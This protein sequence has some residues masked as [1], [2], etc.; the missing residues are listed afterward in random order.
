[1]RVQQIFFM[2]MVI[3]LTACQPSSD[4]TAAQ[5]EVPHRH[6]PSHDSYQLDKLSQT[7]SQTGSPLS[8]R[9]ILEQAASLL[10]TTMLQ[11]PS[12]IWPTY[13]WS[14]VNVMLTAEGEGTI[15]WK[16]SRGGA[17]SDVAPADVPAR[18]TMGMYSFFEYQGAKTVALF[19]EK[20]DRYLDNP[21]AV[22]RIGVH[23]GFHY[24]GQSGWSY[25][26]GGART[27]LL[28]LED[29]PRLYRRLM[30]RRLKEHV[31]SGKADTPSL[32]K[33]AFW[34]Q[35]WKT[36][37]P[38][39]VNSATD[40]YEGTAEY[41]ETLAHLVSLNGCQLSES[42]L[43]QKLIEFLRTSGEADERLNTALDSEGYSMGSMGAYALRFNQKRGDWQARVK[44][45]ETPLEILFANV[46]AEAD[47]E[48]LALAQEYRKEFST[49]SQQYE[50]FIA[51]DLALVKSADAIFVVPPPQ[52]N[53][54]SKGYY[55]FY[56]D[57]SLPNVI[58]GPFTSP[59][60]FQ[61][62]DW[63]LDVDAK[64]N[65]VKLAGRSVPCGG[66]T[67]IMSSSSVV[68][69]EGVLKA[70]GA[71]MAGRMRGELKTDGDGRR[72]FCG[73]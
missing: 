10:T 48:D 28:P 73:Q 11:C 36:E 63:V 14:N 30:Y 15:L 57:R 9:Q 60:R 12:L 24:I 8:K 31:V 17:L 35:K 34:F 37:F 32:R 68:I 70:T 46:S 43:Q 66:H 53:E 6:G 2:V 33:A 7:S 39:E 71:G 27:T 16:G 72:W 54:G 56:S 29:R 21:T 38:H 23:E 26:Q 61:G 67:F 25:K 64:K 50:S 47:A 40:G 13:D 3:S 62:G 20:D 49:Y 59:V 19:M 42:E 45:S 41:T 52:S 22:F 44:T 65:D 55:G 18:A 69:D 58:F 5:A 1:M 51:A 4:K